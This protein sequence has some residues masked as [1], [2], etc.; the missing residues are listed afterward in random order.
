MDPE[1]LLLWNATQDVDVDL[2]IL[3]SID[4]TVPNHK[5][6]NE[7]LLSYLEEQDISYRYDHKLDPAETIEKFR[8]KQKDE[9]VSASGKVKLKPKP[10][11]VEQIE[12]ESLGSKI[13]ETDKL[14]ATHEFYQR[15]NYTARENRRRRDWPRLF[16]RNEYSA[17]GEPY[18]MEE[19]TDSV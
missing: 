11:N 19:D 8:Q 1:D 12:E 10:K 6:A 2:D 5:R 9:L 7:E 18:F 4:N 16:P 3:K 17:D 13:S 14:I 15:Q